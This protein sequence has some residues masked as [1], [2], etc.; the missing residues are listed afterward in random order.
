[1]MD[2]HARQPTGPRRSPRSRSL[3]RRPPRPH[4][5]PHDPRQRPRRLGPH[6]HPA[7]PRP[8]ER[9][10]PHRL[11]LSQLPL[12]R[13]RFHHL[14]AS[15]PHR[16]RRLEKNSSPP[17]PPPRLSH[18]RHQDVPHRLP[19]LSLHPPPHLRSSNPHRPLLP[20]RRPNLPCRLECHATRPHAVRD[21]SRPPHS[22]LGTPALRPHPR[23][24]HPN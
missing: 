23:H 15:I 4:H 3:H 12:P 14:L 19:L 1:M 24:R 6:L 16:T 11:R 18:L 22:L 10:H 20:R 2:H 21:H 5:R 17:H 9:L 8:L 13:R 7:R